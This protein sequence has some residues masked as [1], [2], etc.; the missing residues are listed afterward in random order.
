VPITSHGYARARVKPVSGGGSLIAVANGN[1]ETVGRRLRRMS[2]F[3]VT[4]HWADGSWRMTDCALKTI[5]HS[6]L[7]LT[8]ACT[9]VTRLT[10]SALCC[11]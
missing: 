10:G 11:S 4:D 7:L 5:Y 9:M 1:D 2:R 3:L 8:C 6:T